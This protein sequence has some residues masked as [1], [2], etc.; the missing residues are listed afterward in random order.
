ML[1]GDLLMAMAGQLFTTS[2]L[3]GAFLNRAR[4]LWTVLARELVAA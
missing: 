1:V 2:G 4:P 3:P